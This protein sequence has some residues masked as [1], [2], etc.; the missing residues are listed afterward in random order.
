MKLNNILYQFKE[1]LFN[2]QKPYWILGVLIIMGLSFLITNEKARSLIS[3]NTKDFSQSERKASSID[4]YVPNGYVLVT[5]QLIN[6]EA[7]DPLIGS[8]GMVDLYT[9]QK[10]KGLSSLPSEPSDGEIYYQLIGSYLRL[11][12]APNNQ[13]LFGALV[14]E[15]NRSLIQKLSQPAFAVIH[16]PHAEILPSQISLPAKGEENFK[17]TSPVRQEIQFG[18]IL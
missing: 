13:K 3:S 17:N 7:L 4:T 14:P 12:R 9:V 18:E 2:P 1:N 11:I 10:R 6:A 15:S 8:Y 5:L 16:H